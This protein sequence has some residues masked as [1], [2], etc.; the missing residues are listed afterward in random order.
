ME[1]IRPI[2]VRFLIVC[3]LSAFTAT[4]VAW[5]LSRF[6]PV[7]MVQFHEVDGAKIRDKDIELYVTAVRNR[8]C[9]VHVDRWL[10]Q[11]TDIKDDK[12][13]PVRRYV[14]LP[15]AVAPPTPIG[16]TTT[17]IMSIPLPRNVTPGRWY[18]YSRGFDDCGWFP[19]FDRRARESPV[20]P[21][22]IFSNG[23][24]DGPPTQD[25]PRAN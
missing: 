15:Q 22:T 4:G 16:E 25:L 3:A 17:Y 12:G 24:F 23:D 10:W 21:V 5:S 8:F 11:D 14:T 13:H 20:T 2:W 7:Q 6:P 19:F 1:F 9:S 18:Y